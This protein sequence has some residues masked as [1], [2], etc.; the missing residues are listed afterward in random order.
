LPAYALAGLWQWVQ[1]RSAYWD[2]PFEV[3]ARRMGGV[4]GQLATQT[5]PSS[6]SGP[7][8]R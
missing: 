3:E 1:G 8:G 6:R 7:F 5:G 2:N 4:E